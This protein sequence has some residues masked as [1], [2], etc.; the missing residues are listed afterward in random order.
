MRFRCSHDPADVVARQP[1]FASLSDSECEALVQRS[2]CRGVRR[3]EVLFREGTPCRGLY[4][5][6]EGTV[7]TYRA[8][9]TGQEQVFGVFGAGESLGE[10]SMFDEGPY[11][12]S[13]RVVDDGRVLFLPL[14]EVQALYRTHPEVAHAVVKELGARVRTLAALVDLLSL[15]D[16]PTRVASAVLSHAEAFDALRTGA[17]YRMPRT[18]EELALELGTTREGVARALRRLRT[19]GAIEQRGPMIE[20]RDAALLQQ[21]AGDDRHAANGASAGARSP[22]SS[23]SSSCCA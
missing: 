14:G 18:Q 15:Q 3:G 20:V 9:R 6:V 7:R 1:L 8:N 19:A 23:V 2:V 10:V 11:M 17:V 5:V 16:V 22:A 21:L 13:A 12:A 4:L